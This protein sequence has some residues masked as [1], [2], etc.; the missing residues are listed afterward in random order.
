[1][2]ATNLRAKGGDD[3]HDLKYQHFSIVMNGARRL[4]FS[5]AVNIDGASV[6]KIN[7]KTGKVTSVEV[8]DDE[9]A[10]AYE[11]WFDD[12][13]VDANECSN[14]SLY[15]DP[16]LTQFQ[17]GHL[18]KRTDPSWG[19][20]SRA[21]RAHA[22]TF[23][24]TNCAPQHELFNPNK[25]RWAGVEDWITKESDD[26]DMRV[27]VFSG[28]VLRDNDPQQQPLSRRAPFPHPPDERFLLLLEPDRLP[29]LKPQRGGIA[30]EG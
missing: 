13:R 12:P 15:D 22:D 24:F 11:K 1:M 9:G 14:Q 7:R 27:T 20:A 4:P 3:P 17:R 18:V 29:I 6:V 8:P 26:E 25:T 19:T 2:A 23:H 10:E 21:L 30:H 5:T 16:T 28:P